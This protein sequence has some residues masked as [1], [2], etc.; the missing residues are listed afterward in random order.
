MG[1][2]NTSYTFL[3]TDTITSEKMNNIIDDTT[4]TNTAVLGTTLEV[5]SGQLKVRSGGVTSNEL[6]FDSVVTS[7]IT[8]L[9]VTTDKIVNFGI[10]TGKIADANITAVK[11]ATDSVET[12]KIKDANVTAAKL[13]GAQTGTAPI[14]GARAW[15][16]LNP[17]PDGVRT[18]AYKNGSYSTASGTTTVTIASHGLKANDKIRLDFTTGNAADGLYTVVSSA[19][20]NTFT[21]TGAG[22]TSGNV[23]A[24]FVAIQ[25]SGNISTASWYDSGGDRILLNFATPMPNA[26]YAVSA[27]SQYFPGQWGSEA[28]ED[29][30]GNTQLN[31]VNQA[32][33]WVSES[34]RFTNVVIFG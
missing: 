22:G 2:V 30:L 10:T 24:Q 33:I 13:D 18:T 31:T 26:N 17:Y 6:A 32:H 8:D 29:T 19:D 14:F 34:P 21:V 7:K 20:A 27:T 12:V 5:V 25:G 9:N 23:T 4:F 11:L 1:V 28:Y 16:K 15:A 3:A